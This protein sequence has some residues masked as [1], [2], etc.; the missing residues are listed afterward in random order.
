[1][2]VGQLK[3]YIYDEN[4]VEEIL[5]S[6]GCHHIYYH[7]SGYWTCANKDGDNKQAIVIRNNEYLPCINYTRQ[8]V[9]VDRK[10]DLID[11]V[12]YNNRFTFPEGL[13]YLCELL[14]L[15]YYHDFN[16][17]IPESL[18]ITD[19]ILKMKR[20]D[21]NNSLD[22]SLKP[23][24]E[25]I[26]TYYHN[27]VNDLFYN[28]NIS[29]ETQQD[30]QIGYDAESNRITIPIFSEVGDLVGVKG[31]LFKKELNNYD[32]KYLYL[33]PCPR[34]RVIY[35]LNKSMPYVKRVGRIYVT[36]AEKG[37]MQL[38]TYGDKNAGATGGKELSVQQ[39]ELLTRLSV[40]IVFV[41]DKDVSKD[42]LSSLANKFADGIPIYAVY[43]T[44]NIL[45]EKESPTDS[46]QKWEYLKKNN[47]YRIK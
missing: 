43:D 29:Y 11:L 6:I 44:D 32:L 8:I 4:H 47:I 41:Q 12:C 34:N 22:I 27:R 19:L 9:E 10:T 3:T 30:F 35:G 24:S 45:N 37:V 18:Q 20:N 25:K 40:E 7:S 5:S 15:D 31:R 28:D 13:K 33:E 1:M 38:W 23:I 14:G 17:D 26:L 36:E 2:D 21:N 46:P 16:D 42:E 39:I